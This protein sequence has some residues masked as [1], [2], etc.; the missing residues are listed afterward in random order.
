VSDDSIQKRLYERFKVAPEG[1]ALAFLDESGNY[2]WRSFADLYGAARE[3]AA[4]LA[5][6]G[7]GAGDVCILIPENDEFSS[8]SLLAVLILGAVPICSSPP[9][10]RGHHS[11]LKEVLEYLIRKTGARAVIASD[12][13]APLVEELRGKKRGTRFLF[14]ELKPA[15]GKIQEI[16]PYMPAATDIVAYQLTSGTTGFPKICVWTQ[17]KVLAAL[18]GMVESMKLNSDDICVNWTPLYHDMGLMNNFAL[19]LVQAVPLVMLSTFD[20][21]KDPS[22]WLKALTATRATITW[23]PN[24]GYSISANWVKDEQLEGI[25]L[26]SVR[27]FWNAAERIH[28]ETIEEFQRRFEPYGV[29]PEAMKTNFGMAENVGGATFS[30]PDGMFKWERLD[31]DAL[32]EKG[33]ART[34]G[35]SGSGVPAV[36]VGRPYPGLNIKILSRNLKTLPDGHVG[37]IAFVSPSAMEGYLGNAKETRKALVGD[38]LRTSDMG[39]Q[40]DGELFWTGR[41]K[42]RINVN[43]KKYDPSDFEKAL[44]VVDGLRKGCFAAFGVPEPTVGT[45]RLIIVAEKRSGSSVSDQMLKRSVAGS[46]TSHLGV[47]ASEVILLGEGVMTKTSSGKRRHRYYRQLYLNGEL[48]ECVA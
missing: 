20:F 39:Y 48:Q 24:F 41:K 31:P 32:F 33:I 19:C 6:H 28:I 44:L 35:S 47:K 27:A 43:G 17:Q 18:D 8:K 22:S 12:T 4:V 29:K 34:V 14:G 23:S 15:A 1:N 9:I 46:I 7:V 2:A 11:N 40:R 25:D 10:V 3:H 5:S 38:L 26:S 36:G 13:V 45:E 30:D 42:E 16:T 37:E 21:V